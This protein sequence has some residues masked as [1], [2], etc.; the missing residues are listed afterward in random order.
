MIFVTPQLF[1]GRRNQDGDWRSMWQVWEIREVYK[2][3]W[4]G[5][6]MERG[7]LED[8]GVD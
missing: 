2:G 5:N 8:L 3:F 7:L 1:S 4:W 6:L